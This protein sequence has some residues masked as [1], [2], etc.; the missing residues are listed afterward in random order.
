[1]L[2][3]KD[4][5]R[6]G[7]ALA[8]CRINITADQ[9]CRLCTHEASPIAVFSNHLI[10]R[11]KI[12]DHRRT[13]QGMRH[14]RRIRGP[15]ILAELGSNFEARHLRTLEEQI[16]AERNLFSE[17]FRRCHRFF[18]RRKVTQLIKFIVVRQILFR[19]DAEQLS[20]TEYSGH[21]KQL[22]ALFPRKADKNQCIG[23]F[24]SVGNLF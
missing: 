2:S 11:G 22:S 21:V 16:H 6:R 12:D 8:C 24:R 20:M 13:G 4:E 14:T 19:Y 23:P 9:T 1:M 5:I 10:T 17:K 18:S 3:A 15:E 7:L